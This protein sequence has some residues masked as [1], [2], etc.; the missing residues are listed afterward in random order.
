MPRDQTRE[1][2]EASSSETTAV[3]HLVEIPDPEN[4][5]TWRITN[6]TNDLEFPK[7]SGKIYQS[8]SFNLEKIPIT[9]SD[10]VERT[11]LKAANVNLRVRS[12]IR[13][14]DGLEDEPVKIRKVHP[15]ILGGE[16]DILFEVTYKVEQASWQQ[17]TAVLDLRSPFDRAHQ[18]LTNTITR[19]RFPGIPESRTIIR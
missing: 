11:R 6:W 13:R 19:Q 5:D 15:F 12:I 2:R 10:E 18:K 4:N 17:D 7:N 9:K 16:D 3:V 1:T 8:Y 14:N